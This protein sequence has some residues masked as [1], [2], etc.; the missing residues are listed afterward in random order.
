MKTISTLNRAHSLERVT[1]F[2]ARQ[3][4]AVNIDSTFKR[5]NALTW[6]KAWA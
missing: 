4:E 1:D 3:D 6:A 2:T 5:F